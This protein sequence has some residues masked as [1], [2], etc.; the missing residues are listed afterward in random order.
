[1]AHV[2]KR[3]IR[4]SKNGINLAIEVNAAISDSSG[5]GSVASATSVSDTPIVQGP[6]GKP[7]DR[8]PKPATNQP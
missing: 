1:M 3:T 7:S 2:I 4:R 8:G 6:A 5:S